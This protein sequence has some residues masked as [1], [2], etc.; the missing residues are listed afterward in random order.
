MK[1][2]KFFFRLTLTYKDFNY[3]QK[4]ALL[5]ICSRAKVDARSVRFRRTFNNVVFSHKEKFEFIGIYPVFIN[6]SLLYSFFSEE[7]MID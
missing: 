2:F 4:K 3:A 5:D 1:K 6:E 7:N